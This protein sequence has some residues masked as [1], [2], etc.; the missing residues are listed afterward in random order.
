MRP[1]Q[2]DWYCPKGQYRSRVRVQIL[3]VC[4]KACARRRLRVAKAGAL[5]LPSL[6]DFGGFDEISCCCRHCLGL[7]IRVRRRN[8]AIESRTMRR[9]CSE[10]RKFQAHDDGG[11][12]WCRARC[13]R[14]CDIRWR[15]RT[16][17]RRRCSPWR[18]TAS[19]PTQ[20]RLPILL[21][22]LHAAV[23]RILVRPSKTI[24]WLNAS[25]GHL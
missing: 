6:K 19:S 5:G 4:R 23:I 18:Y 3:L 17:C 10:R 24:V 22:R 12:T 15:C 13:G 9:L 20:P 11:C 1:M 7:H 21:R 2:L 16:R 25:A 8:G 14:C